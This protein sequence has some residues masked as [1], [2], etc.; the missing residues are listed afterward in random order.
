[1]HDGIQDV[2]HLHVAAICDHTPLE[3]SWVAT[4][5]QLE[6]Y[7]Q[8]CDALLIYT[9]ADLKEVFARNLK[10]R[11]RKAGLPISE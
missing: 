9:V 10:T 6:L 3:I 8:K 7:C 2:Y 5:G 1:M 4:A 11:A